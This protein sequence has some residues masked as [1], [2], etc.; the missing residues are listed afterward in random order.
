MREDSSGSVITSTDVHLRGDLESQQAGVIVGVSLSLVGI[1]VLMLL[2]LAT[3][4]VRKRRKEKIVED[5]HL[6]LR[7]LGKY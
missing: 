2:I 7:G 4:L 3:L 1:I 6:Q 5:T